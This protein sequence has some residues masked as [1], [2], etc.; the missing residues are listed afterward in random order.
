MPKYIYMGYNISRGAFIVPALT[1]SA[2]TVRQTSDPVNDVLMDDDFVTLI[3]R[4]N[5]LIKFTQ[6]LQ[7]RVEALE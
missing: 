5:G 1:I 3:N 7:R 6:E 2:P 4:V